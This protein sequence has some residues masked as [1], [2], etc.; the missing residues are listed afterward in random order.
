MEETITASIARDIAKNNIR[1]PNINQLEI[2]EQ[3]IAESSGK[4][5][6]FCYLYHNITR[7]IKN[8]LIERGFIIEDMTRKEGKTLFKIY[9]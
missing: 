1:Q 9:W 6:F 4:N 3:K 7:V 8:D 5:Q 2:I